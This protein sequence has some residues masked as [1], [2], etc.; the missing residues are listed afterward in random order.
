ML[1]C[2]QIKTIKHLCLKTLTQFHDL[3]KQKPQNNLFSF[4]EFIICYTFYFEN[5]NLRCI[6]SF[7]IFRAKEP[8]DVVTMTIN[9][10]LLMNTPCGGGG[11]CIFKEES[12]RPFICSFISFSYYNLKLQIKYQNIL[13]YLWFHVL[14]TS[15]TLLELKIKINIIIN[16]NI[17]QLSSQHN[18]YLRF[19]CISHITSKWPGEKQYFSR[20][21]GNVSTTI[22]YRKDYSYVT[23]WSPI[24]CFHGNCRRVLT[25][26][27]HNKLV[28]PELHNS[29]TSLA[30]T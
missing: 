20:I 14:S 7:A 16:I 18:L 19:N 15:V 13:L 29:L 30:S 1:K 21:H 26:N 28:S 12:T 10:F 5:N 17:S 25:I 8:R 11:N 24:T 4:L 6:I 22:R 2:M 3:L 9:N 27:E 23:I